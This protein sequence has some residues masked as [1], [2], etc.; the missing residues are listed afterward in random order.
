[1]HEYQASLLF[2]TN[3]Y[4]RPGN[5]LAGTHNDNLNLRDKIQATL[6]FVS[7]NCAVQWDAQNTLA[8]VMGGLDMVLAASGGLDYFLCQFSCHGGDNPSIHEPDGTEGVIICHDADLEGPVWKNVLTETM[9][10]YK[11]ME[12]SMTCLG[13]FFMDLCQSGEFA[14]LEK[15]AHSHKM[16]KFISRGPGP[17]KEVK[18]FPPPLLH[19][20]AQARKME[21]IV[22]W[23]ACQQT[24]TAAEDY[25][26]GKAQGAFT[27]ALCKEWV[28]G[29]SRGELLDKI[30]RTL[31]LAGYSQRPMLLC[32]DRLRGL[33]I[34]EK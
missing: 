15:L 23:S 9:L 27:W 21:N 20:V 17:E 3:R 12:L 4:V 2:G 13:E 34:G 11:L 32:N 5:N 31:D 28:P 16:V 19:R 10:Y 22:I 33:P 26:G 14:E 18:E 30:T 29:I 8:G 25:I 6:G 24:Q 1:M 7:N